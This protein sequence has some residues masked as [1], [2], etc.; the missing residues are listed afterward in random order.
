MVDT[1]LLLMLARTGDSLQGIKKGVLELADVIAVNKADGDRVTEAA[2]AAKELAAALHFVAPSPYGWDPPV[3]TCSSLEG[4]GLD[5]VWAQ[6]SAHRAHLER[7]GSLRTHRRDQDVESMWAAIDDHLLSRFRA[8]PAVRRRS[9][10]LEA[11]VRDGSM[12]AMA[13]AA[14]LLSLATD[15]AVDCETEMSHKAPEKETRAES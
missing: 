13:A 3:L 5:E 12:T 10:E 15:S 8:T 14:A 11:A 6:I 4:D 9:A 1:F 2:A 7:L